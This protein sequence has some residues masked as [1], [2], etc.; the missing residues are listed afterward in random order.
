MTAAHFERGARVA[1]IRLGDGFVITHCLFERC[2]ALIRAVVGPF[3]V[4]KIN[5]RAKSAS[6]RASLI[7]SAWASS[8]CRTWWCVPVTQ[9]LE[10]ESGRGRQGV[11]S[12]WIRAA[13]ASTRAT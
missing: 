10:V 1:I 13:S 12:V 7:L 2:G 5:G 4:H 3:V 8:I 6:L 9:R 11:S